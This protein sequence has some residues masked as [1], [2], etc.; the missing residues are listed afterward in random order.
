MPSVLI[1]TGFLSNKNDAAYLKSSKGQNEIA[2]AVFKAIKSFRE[3][4]EKV[5]ETEL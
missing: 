4:Y 2:G 1:E 3:Y 5:M